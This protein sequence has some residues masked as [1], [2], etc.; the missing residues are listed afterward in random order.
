MAT[1]A[2]KLDG[3]GTALVALAAVITVALVVA[4]RIEAVATTL[5][6]EQPYRLVAVDERGEPV[7]GATLTYG[8]EQAT[9]DA[10]GVAELRLRAPELA[11]V[12]APAMLPDAVV[13]GSAETPEVTV[14]LLD[15]TGPGGERTVMHFAGDFMMGRRYLEPTH[16]DTPLVTDDESARA[17][18]S[19]IAPLFRLADISSVNYESVLGTLAASDAYP[20]KKFLLQS[21]PETVAALDELGVDVATLGNNHIYDWLEPGVAST[22]RHL[23]TAGIAHPG[24]GLS[25]AEAIRPVMIEAGTTQIAMISM[26][27][28]SGDFVNDQLPDATAPIP[29]AT[30]E[31]DRWPYEERT[32]GFGVPGDANYV[33]TADRRPGAIWDIYSELEDTLRPGDATDLWQ[34][35]IRTYPELQDSVARRGHGGAAHFSRNAVQQSVDAA[36]DAGADLVVVQLHGGLTSATAPTAFFG[37]AARAAVDA[38]AD[39]VVGHHPHVL[40]GFEFY[41]DTLIASSLGNFVF[42]QDLLATHP[43]VILRTVFEGTDLIEASLYPLIL[44]RYRPVAVG[45]AA[46]TE[47]LRHTSR[48][49]LQDAIALRLPDLTT[50]AIRTTDDYGAMVVGEGPRGIILPREEAAITALQIETDSPMT[51]P[52]APFR[53]VAPSADLEIGTDIYGYGSLEDVQADGVTAGGL[54]WSLPPSS[55]EI[56]TDSPAGPWTVRL[57]RT[58]QHL[59]DL[60]ARTAAR[61]SLPAHRWFDAAGAPVD[62]SPSYAV[63]VW[64][65]RVGAGIPFVRIAFYE[66]DDT[67]LVRAPTS[68]PAGSA[69]VELPL[70]NDGEWHEIWVEFPDPPPGANAALVGVGLAPPE[71]HSGTVW[72]DGLQVIEWRPADRI[73]AGTWLTAEYLRAP[74]GTNVELITPDS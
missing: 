7:A 50:A 28:L 51:A 44:D 8:E 19:T 36:R 52:G 42:D 57:D 13:I 46:A 74:P 49:S 71:S 29:A 22:L 34:E 20:G 21:P 64:A 24:G 23:D 31:A 3:G 10:G 6:P 54:E 2:N 63:R 37:D 60:V 4:W 41:N 58:S 26:T 66:F 73:P 32:F 35:I 67:D 27:T 16:E 38:G 33:P 30:E 12:E 45:G 70:V 9:T 11:V 15:E 68:T 53:L 62:G 39:L 59:N 48:A 25:A 61:V 47:I 55:L 43:S 56:A 69:D 18:V 14:R 1:R 65:K 17:V 5:P 40:Q 72:I